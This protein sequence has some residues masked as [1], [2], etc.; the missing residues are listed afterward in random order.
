[1]NF[2][3]PFCFALVCCVL[4]LCLSAPP[5]STVISFDSSQFNLQISWQIPV[6]LFSPKLQ[7]IRV[8][9]AR[10]RFQNLEICFCSDLEHAPGLSAPAASPARQAPWLLE[11]CRAALLQCCGNWIAFTDCLDFNKLTFTY[12]KCHVGG[13]SAYSINIARENIKQKETF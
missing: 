13:F 4:G 8:I 10:G 6:W 11:S 9:L 7:L 3:K 1:M 2:E 12:G 5:V